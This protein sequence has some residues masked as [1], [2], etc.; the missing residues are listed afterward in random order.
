MNTASI[1][2][3]GRADTSTLRSVAEVGTQLAPQ[4]FAF[5][6]IAASPFRARL[7]VAS[8]ACLHLS[9]GEYGPGVQLH[10]TA[11]PGTVVVALHSAAGAVRGSTRA[12]FAAARV[13]LV[14]RDGESGL[15]GSWVSGS[16][17]MVVTRA[18][19]AQVAVGRSFPSIDAHARGNHLFLD[20][21]AGRR[22]VAEAWGR[23]IARALLDP[24]VLRAPVLAARM[25]EAAIATLLESLDTGPF[26]EQAA[27]ETRRVEAARRGEEFMRAHLEERIAVREVAQSAG[28]TVRS[29]ER[30]FLE[31][32]GVAPK[33][34]LQ[35]LRLNAA[36]TELV[37]ADAGTTVREVAARWRQ[38][39]LGRFAADYSRI[40]GEPP[41]KTLQG[42]RRARAVSSP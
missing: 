24:E 26:P 9:R 32:F 4:G 27:A 8:T 23:I 36:R 16:L 7:D 15:V 19:M 30:G 17:A 20:A 39:H 13:A 31:A 29:L 6:R 28:M 14:C 1:F 10:V 22:R 2:P 3:A 11:P 38:S 25:E 42:R 41:G 12:G 33:A 5:D 21:A 18:R 40:F 35:I 37:G 34:Y